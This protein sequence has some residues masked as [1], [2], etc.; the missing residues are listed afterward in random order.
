MST[1]SLRKHAIAAAVV[2]LGF[3][4]GAVAQ[5]AGSSTTTPSGSSATSA[6]ARAD[7]QGEAKLERSE[8]KFIEET[9]AH[10][11]AEV[12]LGKLAQQK[13]SSDQVKQF[14]ERMVKDHTKANDELKQIAAAKGVELPTEME[15]EHRREIEKLSKLSG[16]EF[17]REYMKAM[18]DDHEKDVKKFEKMAEDAKDPQVK[19]FASSTLPVLKQHEQLA[20][21]THA[22][23]KDDKP[24][25]ASSDRA[26]P[27]AASGSVSTSGTGST[28][29]SGTSGSME[30]GSSGSSGSSSGSMGG[31]SKERKY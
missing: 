4:M 5:T 2:S 29:G 31:D 22:A 16:E 28:S 3:T 13:G 12:E 19:E 23:L 25:T 10:G 30:S 17:D 11:M 20:E 24:S 1:I 6:S 8:R 18:V 15:R 26:D 21:T 9:A 27:G 14:G 7:S